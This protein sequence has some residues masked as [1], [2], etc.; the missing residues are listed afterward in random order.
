MSFLW[1]CC[2]TESIVTQVSQEIKE[3]AINLVLFKWIDHRS[4]CG[5]AQSLHYI[6]QVPKAICQHLCKSLINTWYLVWLWAVA[7]NPVETQG[8]HCFQENNCPQIMFQL[9]I[10]KSNSFWVYLMTKRKNVIS[11]FFTHIL[12][13]L[14]N[15]SVCRGDHGNWFCLVRIL[16]LWQSARLIDFPVAGKLLTQQ[17]SLFVKTSAHSACH[18]HWMFIPSVGG[19]IMQW[20]P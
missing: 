3:L 11:S 6:Y 2:N 5:W 15:S 10:V 4:Q 14:V 12:L 16:S 9:N 1:V 7:R 19:E 20:H 17:S 18:F 13:F 8:S